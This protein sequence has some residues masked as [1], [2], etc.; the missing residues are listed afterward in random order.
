MLRR[1]SRLFVAPPHQFSSM[2]SW[3]VMSVLPYVKGAWSALA[4]G[5]TCDILSSGG[6]LM[7]REGV[8]HNGNGPRVL[9]TLR[10]V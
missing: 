6:C 5:V 2:R 1:D 3:P 7:C 8:R 4:P 10:R 9:V